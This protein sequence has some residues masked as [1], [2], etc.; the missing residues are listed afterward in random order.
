MARQTATTGQ[1]ENAQGIMLAVSRFTAEHSAP[2]ANLIEHMTL[3]QGDKQITVPKVAQMTMQSL[4]DGVDMVDSQAIGMTTVDLTTGEAGLKVIVTKK[5]LR[6]ANDKVFSMVGKQIGDAKSRKYDEDIIAL[7]SALNGGTTLGADD[8][9][10]T[11]GNT[12]AA[13]AFAKAN[14]Y[15][16]PVQIVHHPYAVFAL[17]NSMAISPAATYPIPKGYAEDLLSDFYRIKLNGIPIFEDGNIAKITSV[18]SGYGAIFSKSAMVLVESLA[19]V[20]EREEDISLRAWEV[21][22]TCDYGVF[23]LDDTYG[24]PLRFEIGAPSTSV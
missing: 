18:D 17:T 24:A 14:K 20:V 2:C 16:S 9:N 6:Q 3:K 7:F 5:L 19:P 23:E 13:I 21:V 10:M 11:I 4:T 8:K 22:L 15:P 1:L 12:A